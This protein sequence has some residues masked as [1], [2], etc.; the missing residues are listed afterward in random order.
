M[1]HV[2]QV[3]QEASGSD[4]DDELASKQTGRVACQLEAQPPATHFLWTFIGLAEL[5]E[6]SAGK[7]W[8]A[9]PVGG[10]GPTASSGAGQ[11]AGFASRKGELSRAEL[12]ALTGGRRTGLLLCRARNELGWQQQP[13]QNLILP[14]GE[15]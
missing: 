7:P 9:S 6:S 12:L 13:C 11:S 1:D 8:L 2:W 15:F 5:A 4:E 14:A 3:E 10:E